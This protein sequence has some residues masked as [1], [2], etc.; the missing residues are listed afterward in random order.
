[1]LMGGKAGSTRAILLH[2]WP[3]MET[4]AN[5]S[6]YAA[7]I[8]GINPIAR[9]IILLVITERMTNVTSPRSSYFM[10]VMAGKVWRRDERRGWL[11]KQGKERENPKSRKGIFVARARWHTHAS[12][13]RAVTDT[14]SHTHRETLNKKFQIFFS[15]HISSYTKILM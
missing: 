3:M 1:M 15:I 11:T 2:L 12:I 7:Y 14:H 9:I 4:A 13:L 10:W 8:T 6:H 5:M